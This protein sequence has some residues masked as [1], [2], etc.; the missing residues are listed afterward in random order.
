MDAD[1]N[2]VE[3]SSLLVTGQQALTAHRY[4][5]AAAAAQRVRTL[6]GDP[7]AA[8]ELLRKATAGPTFETFLSQA[9]AAL[10]RNSFGEAR[11]D[12]RHAKDLNVDGTR[13]D[14]LSARVDT[15]EHTFSTKLNAAEQQR[16]GMHDFFSGDYA[17]AITVLAPVAGSGVAR[18]QLYLASAEAAQSILEPDEAKRSQLAANARRDWSPIAGQRASFT[19][20]LAYLSPAIAKVLGIAPR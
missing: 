1:I 20:D 18:A 16:M 14:A 3:A 13:V 15:A 7:T 5:D 6:G 19:A 2:R 17:G 4:A 11:E 10:A 12:T 8:D 9:T